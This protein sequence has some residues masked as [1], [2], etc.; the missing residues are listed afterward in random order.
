MKTV[1][2]SKM[3][4]FS[5]EVAMRPYKY[6]LYFVE[7]NTLGTDTPKIHRLY[8]P[9]RKNFK[10]FVLGGVYTLSYRRICIKKFQFN[11]SYP[12]TEDMYRYLIELRDI[13]FMDKSFSNRLMRSGREYNTRDLYYTLAETQELLNYEPPFWKRF[14]HGVLQGVTYILSLIVPVALYIVALYSVSSYAV[15]SAS[16]MMRP[17][18]VPILAIAS[19][20]LLIYLMMIIYKFCELFMLNISLTRYQML[21]SYMLRWAGIRKS[22]F[23]EKAHQKSILI[24]GIVSVSILLVAILFV[25]ILF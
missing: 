25:L 18:V 15:D 1:T 23:I 9:R 8:V 2:R 12:L 10:K 22:C 14:L 13:K 11:E 19:L 20:P 21:K 17:V 4:L 5:I 7:L 16:D 24:N 6:R 3:M